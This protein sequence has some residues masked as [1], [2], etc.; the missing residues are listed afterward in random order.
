MIFQK[1]IPRGIIYHTLTEDFLNIFKCLFVKLT[2]NEEILR[3]ENVFA[4]YN[5]SKYCVAFP[6][7][8]MGIFYS[9][10]ASKL[11]KGSEIIMPPIT[12]KAIL[13]VV[14]EAGLKPVFVD[15][16]LDDFSYDLNDLKKKINK[17]TKSILISYLYGIIPD[18]NKIVN[19]AKEH[20]LFIMEDFSQCLNGKYNDK[21]TGNFGHIGI[22][23]SSTTKTLDTY[24]GGLCVT[25]SKGYY[26]QLKMLQEKQTSASRINLFKKVL[27]DFIRN[28]LT[29]IIF[30]NLFT[31]RIIKIVQLFNKD[32]LVKYV[33]NKNQEPL[34]KF[35]K[36][37]YEKFTS[38]QA[39]L[40][41]KYIK[42]LDKQDSS[43]KENVE[44]IKSNLEDPTTKNESKN[45]VYWQFLYLFKDLSQKQVLNIFRKYKI[46]TSRSS[47]PLLPNLEKYNF[48]QTTPNA[49]KIINHGYFIPAYHRL[50]K[51][52]LKRLSK[53]ARSL[54]G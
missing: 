13:D 34:K 12:I 2:S 19:I 26:D 3:F 35:P 5:G 18:V 32:F 1:Y 41:I 45:N 4:E 16:N 37:Y 11:P 36:T 8:R 53:L 42:Y 47:L 40:G 15:L 24:G 21:K 7:A 44:F 29:N 27:L 30:F 28:L 17:N 50:T 20:D 14:L 43:R 25:N 31:I 51:N 46:D 9:I 49:E 54:D 52:D 22:Y 39:K 38:F 33:G 48:N 6:Y 23:S 10:K